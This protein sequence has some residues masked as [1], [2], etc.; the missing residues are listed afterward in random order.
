MNYLVQTHPGT[1]QVAKLEPELAAGMAAL[2]KPIP[3]YRKQAAYEQAKLMGVQDGK[4]YPLINSVS[5]QLERDNPYA[6]M[7][8]GMRYLDLTGVYR[9]FAYLLTGEPT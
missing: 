7:E 5:E 2:G 1:Q 9:L 4:A 8:I 6:A 3:Y